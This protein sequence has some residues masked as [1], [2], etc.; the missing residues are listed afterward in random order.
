SGGTAAKTLLGRS[1]GITRLRGRWFDF[2]PG[3]GEPAIPA[4]ATF[5]PSYLLRTPTAKREAWRDLLA[6]KRK[7]EELTGIRAD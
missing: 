4:I 2:E 6:V 1:E 5:H 7:L 3:A